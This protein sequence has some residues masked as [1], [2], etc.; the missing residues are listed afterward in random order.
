VLH[1]K[2]LPQ[3]QP[4]ALT[5]NFLQCCQGAINFQGCASLIPLILDALSGE[6]NIVLEDKHVSP[7]ARA[8]DLYHPH[9]IDTRPH[10]IE[11]VLSYCSLSSVYVRPQ[12]M[13]PPT[14]DLF[15]SGMPIATTM[16]PATT[17]FGHQEY[18]RIH[19]RGSHG[20]QVSCKEAR[21]T[22]RS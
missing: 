20:R 19:H 1:E 15:W 11:P 22:K 17:Y 5:T 4:V 9:I 12:M 8:L 16:A 10:F 18:G 14:L 21:D 2:N 3:V 7:L 13:L 6:C